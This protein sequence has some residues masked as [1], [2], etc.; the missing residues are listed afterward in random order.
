MPWFDLE[1]RVAG[2]QPPFY[3]WSRFGC[4]YKIPMNDR[5]ILDRAHSRRLHGDTTWRR[6]IHDAAAIEITAPLQKN[7]LFTS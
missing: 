6:K 7:R 1:L 2:F 4:P 5:T 3:H